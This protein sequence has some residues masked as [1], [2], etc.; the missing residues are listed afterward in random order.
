MPAMNNAGTIAYASSLSGSTYTLEIQ[1]G[2]NRYSLPG[3]NTTRFVP[4]INELGTV[5]C[6]I[7]DG[8]KIVIG[9]GISA[10]RYIDGS[11]YKG[12]IE[13]GWVFDG[14]ESICAINDEGLVV[15]GARPQPFIAPSDHGPYGLFTG[16]DPV[17]D[18]II[19]EG[20]ML[21]GAT[22]S[23]NSL[24]FARNGLNNSG[25][26]AFIATLSNG[27]SGVWVATPVPEPSTLGL[28]AAGLISLLAC[29]WRR[30]ERM[31]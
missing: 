9:D 25:Q 2:A 16:P 26:I 11:L 6:V 5:A 7:N 8:A 29:V 10:P 30:K 17:A 28:M 13:S 14:G 1:K 20:D 23:L 3:V 27:T 15:F 19:M 12:K 24:S 22:I 31:A 18:K 4:D 21:D